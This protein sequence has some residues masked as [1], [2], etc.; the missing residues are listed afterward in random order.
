MQSH[1][2]ELFKEKNIFVG[3]MNPHPLEKKIM[4]RINVS[5]INELK[6]LFTKTSSIIISQCE[7]LVSII[8]KDLKPTV[9]ITPKGKGKGKVKV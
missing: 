3:Y 2:N 8:S 1:I 4:F 5:N 6:E 7:N 9:K